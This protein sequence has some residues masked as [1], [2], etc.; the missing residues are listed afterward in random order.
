MD[1]ALYASGQVGVGSQGRMDE[2][3]SNQGPAEVHS[4]GEFIMAERRR[5]SWTR[6][7]LTDEVRRAALPE[8]AT[9]GVQTVKGW[10]LYGI[11]PQPDAMRWLARALDAPVER[12]VSLAAGMVDAKEG[13]DTRRRDFLTLLAA[14]T[15]GLIDFE[16]LAAPTVDTLWLRDAEAVSM[17]IAAQRSRVAPGAL[18][19]A[20]LGH[21]NALEARLP[22]CEEL[23]AQTALLSGSLLIKAGWL[24]QAYRCY[25][26]AE[27]LGEPVVRAKAQTG[28]AGVHARQGDA[29]R[30]LQLQS[31]AVET[32]KGAPPRARAGVLARLAELRAEAG[33]DAGAMRDLDAAEHG[34]NAGS[35]EWFYLSPEHSYEVGAYRGSVLATLGRHR[36][37]IDAYEWTLTR[38]DPALIDWRTKIAQDRDRALAAL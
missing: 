27:S 31:H 7:R 24:P 3:R 15:A 11:R 30:A 37:A 13:E 2:Q 12:L 23:T 20:V 25:S 4:L 8:V 35:Y 1:P 26:L 16:R 5:R 10:E 17:A 19:P 38:M 6:R 29:R 21:L 22:A 33:Q 34:I 28:R 36:E 9:T 18:V 32:L 14:G